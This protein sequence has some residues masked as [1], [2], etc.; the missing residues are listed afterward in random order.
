MKA[1]SSPVYAIVLSGGGAR[2][3]YEAGVMHYIR[4]ALPKRARNQAFQIYCGSSVGAINTCSL[5]SRAENPESQGTQLRAAWDNLRQENIYRRDMAALSKLLVN[6]FAGMAS[7][8]FRKPKTDGEESGIHFHGLVDTS[9]LEK[10]LQRMIAWDQLKLNVDRKI[11]HG[12]SVT[13]TNMDSGQLEFFIHKHPSVEYHGDYPVRFLPLHWKHVMGSAAIPILF[14]AVEINQTYYADGGLRLNTPMSPAIHMGADRLLV[15]GMHDSQ[16]GSQGEIEVTAP[17][18]APPTLGEII[19]KI[20]NSIFLDRLDHDL[21]QMQRINN[22]IDW[23]EKEYG[24]D[25]LPRVNKMLQREGIKGDVASRGLRRLSVLQVSP[26]VDVREIFLDVLLSPKGQAAFSSYEKFLLKMLD[27]DMH[28]GQ[29]FLSYF[30]FLNDYLKALTQ[31]GYEDAK[32]KHD[33]LTEFLSWEE[34]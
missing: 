33:Q 6:S 10:F 1:K 11:V 23:S 32:K 31:L 20:L 15:I 2:G 29:E 16:E 18:L 34:A 22:I 3:A 14:P 26:T 12:V 28:R 4:T 25:Y 17:R 21:R 19:G 30:L 27:V 13:L 5:A 7:N 8:I 24:L 9:P